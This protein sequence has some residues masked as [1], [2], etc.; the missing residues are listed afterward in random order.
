[1]GRVRRGGASM[2]IAG[3]RQA[4]DREAAVVSS[5]STTL[6]PGSES[7]PHG[8]VLVFE[9]AQFTLVH[10]SETA[11]RLLSIELPDA[12]GQPVEALLGDKLALRLRS[13]Q[14]HGHER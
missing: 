5:R 13:A 9:R 12:F 8:C 10:A 3:L 11:P 6:I 2:D 14:P 7:Q 4:A 1:M